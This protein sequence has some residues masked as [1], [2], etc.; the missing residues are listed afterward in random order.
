MPNNQSTSKRHF[1]PFTYFIAVIAALAGL[2]FGLD[3]G[4]I[5]GALPILTHIFHIDATTQGLVVSI[6]LIGAVAGTF[7]SM[8]ISHYLGRRSALIISTILFTL[9][10]IGSAFAP[11]VAFLI[12]VRFFL[13]IALGIAAY[14]T[15]L[16][17]AEITP[18]KIRGA[19]I[20]MYQLMITIGLAAAF[21]SDTI[22]APSGN[23][24]LMLGIV[25]IPSFLM[26][27][28]M[29]KLPRSPRWLMLKKR[30]YEAKS[31]LTKIFYGNQIDAALQKIET[32]IKPKHSVTKHLIWRRFWPVLALGLGA[33]M[34]QQWT[35]INVIMYYAPTVFKAAGFASSAQQMWC[36]VAVG[37]IN[38]LSTIV[39]IKLVDNKG[40]KLLLYLGL[41]I[42]TIAL[43]L[44][45][46]M[47]HLPHTNL[48][49]YTSVAGILLYIFGFA[50]SLGPVVWIICAEIFPLQ[51]RDLG[52]MLTIAANWAYNSLLANSFP[53]LL[54]HFGIS[55]LFLSFAVLSIIGI[56]FVRCFI[57]ETKGANLED[58]EANLMAGKPLRKLGNTNTNQQKVS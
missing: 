30:G 49:K 43:L 14:T 52:I 16:Y 10:A 54:K 9:G 56:V 5:S 45:Y 42:M 28:G 57:P 15:P 19:M 24:R 25:A 55:T 46:A 18:E 31:V 22:L 36:T 6:L 41:S 11:N 20:S 7:L 21:I 3:T 1:K 27:L 33:Q 47:L 50:I 58:I 53:T 2:L 48:T 40:R 32:N 17:L 39:A 44:T 35:G 23:W 8:P 12:T 26:L 29:I 38:V 34:L 51:L 13:G 37:I 4:V